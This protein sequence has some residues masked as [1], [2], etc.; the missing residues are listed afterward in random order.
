MSRRSAHAV[1]VV[2][3]MTMMAGCGARGS[4]PVKEPVPTST[5]QPVP[6][7]AGEWQPMG[8]APLSPR[9]GALPVWTGER[10]LLLGGYRFDEQQPPCPPAAA[11]AAVEPTRFDD[12]AAWDPAIGA[13]THLVD[14]SGS[15]GRL[16]QRGDG[17][18]WSGTSLFTRGQ[19]TTPDLAA[20][21]LTSAPIDAGPA[22]VD[23]D[24][25]WAGDRLVT[26]GWDYGGSAS[27]VDGQ[28][29]AQV[30]EPASGAR[31]VV[32]WPY[33]P[34]GAES[35]RTAWTGREVVA[36]VATNGASE[37]DEGTSRVVAF[38][39]AASTWRT[40]AERADGPV[41]IA[42]DGRRLLLEGRREINAL[43]VATGET[44]GVASLPDHA[45]G[46]LQV[47]SSG[48]MLLQT[49]RGSYLLVEKDDGAAGWLRV[50]EPP[51]ADRTTE[52]TVAWAGDDLVVWGGTQA[53][54]QDDGATRSTADGWVWRGLGGKQLTS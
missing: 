49:W 42:W 16:S 18:V 19:Q 22:L 17:T 39:S 4:E 2:V 23:A 27:G 33:G 40:I 5:V 3:L 13:W 10:L 47:S 52:S 25:V 28:L 51:L 29:V 37:T 30:F 48:R 53:S 9:G 14:T 31:A 43:D 15:L 54:E 12:G 38:D 46:E 36:F 6:A 45:D 20:G 26:I 11:C 44:T 1:A 41:E 7:S 8:A 32:P 34:P 24:P 35:V 21:T 50:P